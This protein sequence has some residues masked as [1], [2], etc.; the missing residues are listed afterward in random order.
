M[1]GSS[2][3]VSL[4]VGSP[5][6]SA[7]LDGARARIQEEDWLGDDLGGSPFFG[8][9]F[10]G[11]PTRFLKDELPFGCCLHHL[12]VIIAPYVARE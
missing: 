8:G 6:E 3:A 2:A 10:D 11:A 5:F 7:S 1:P 9:S 4:V 12:H